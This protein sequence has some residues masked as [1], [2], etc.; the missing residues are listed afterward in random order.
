MKSELTA[1]I[2]RASARQPRARNCGN[3][4]IAAIRAV[5]FTGTVVAERLSK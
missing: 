2:F 3:A 4:C 5:P 1:S